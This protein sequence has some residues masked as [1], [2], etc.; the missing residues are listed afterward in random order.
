MN[1]PVPAEVPAGFTPFGIHIG[2]AQLVGPFYS[3]TDDDGSVTIGFRVAE[4]HCNAFPMAHGG[5]TAAFADIVASYVVWTA[6]TPRGQVLTISLT[7]DFI[8]TAPLGAWVEGRARLVS[9]G[10]SVAFSSCEIYAD[11]KL[12]MVASGKFRLRPLRKAAV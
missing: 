5:M 6:Q 2:F 1:E 12:V 3:R 7:T 10:T 4:R 11:N 9:K 8:N